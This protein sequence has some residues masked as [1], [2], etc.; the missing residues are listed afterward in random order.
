MKFNPRDEPVAPIY[1]YSIDAFGSELV[2]FFTGK[3]T[4]VFLLKQ[5]GDMDDIKKQNPNVKPPFF[6]YRPGDVSLFDEG[7]SNERLQRMGTHFGGPLSSVDDQGRP[8]DPNKNF[9]R[10]NAVNVELNLNIEF[11]CSYSEQIHFS[12]IWIP[13]AVRPL[14]FEID[15]KGL[16]VP[17]QMILDK[18]IT[19]SDID[20]DN[21]SLVECQTNCVLRTWMAT[22]GTT[23]PISR[24]TVPLKTVGQPTGDEL[25]HRF[26]GET[27]ITLDD[28]GKLEVGS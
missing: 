6:T 18:S 1:E 16:I 3:E 25:G 24:Y 4:P 23:R 2:N 19:Y 5:Q 8:T 28:E 20:F 9:S 22:E 17:C 14:K 15:Y 26:Y 11:V 12:Q 10:L 7:Q 13:L 27:Q 21:D